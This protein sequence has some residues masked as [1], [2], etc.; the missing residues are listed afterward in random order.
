MCQTGA[1]MIPKDFSR[2]YLCGVIAGSA[3]CRL[4]RAT[5]KRSPEFVH[6][7]TLL[8][9]GGPDFF[10]RDWQAATRPPM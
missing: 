7:R 10:G 9:H 4:R 3:A 1:R 2:A 5:E 6:F 8:L